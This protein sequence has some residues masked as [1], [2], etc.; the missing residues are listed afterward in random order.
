MMRLVS[1][2]WD[3]IG[4]LRRTRDPLE[5]TLECDVAIVGGG[6][7]GLWTALELRRADPSLD[8][9]VLEREAC[10]FGASGRNG[11]W[12]LG[13]LAGKPSERLTAAI[14]ATVDE[15]AAAIER[16]GIDC[17]LVKGGTLSVALDDVN[18]ARLQSDE[19]NVSEPL[20][21][22]RG[23]WI[24]AG[25]LAQRVRVAGARGATFDPDCA[26]I[27]PAKL[28][29][30]L[31]DA[32]ERAGARIF[33]GTA[34]TAIDPHVARTAAGDVRAR[35]VV[36]ATEGYTPGAGLA[37]ISSSMIVTE[38]L[39]DVAWSEIGWDGA[40]TMMVAAHAYCYL[41]RTADGRI[42]I[43]GRG[44]PYRWRGANTR[45]ERPD[46][47]TIAS[48]RSRLD[49]LFPVVRDVPTDAAWT[50][51]LGVARDWTPAVRADPATGLAFAGG[52]VGEGVAAANL[53]GRTLRD[54]VLGRD[55]EL[56]RLDWVGHTSPRWEP[57]PLRWIGIRTVYALYRAAD[58]AEARTGRLSRFAAVAS[59]LAGR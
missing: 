38:P 48:L 24:D 6:Y 27:H 45:M 10:G 57:D 49:A 15:A 50:G 7:T 16:E 56:T 44:T 47:R 23:T 41:Q 5:G 42:A 36:R 26:R 32:A 37:P 55:T 2:W 30:G 29:R 51:V 59:R 11:G 58:R 14:R 13:E 12:L 1:F 8:V 17:D 21:A 35:W 20:M 46:D 39:P 18:A 53:A 33:E 4:G 3:D 19:V 25:A 34:A 31:A 28:V 54:L 9:V 40:E 43:G 22:P 52:Y